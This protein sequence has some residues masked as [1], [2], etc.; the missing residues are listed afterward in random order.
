MFDLSH[1]CSQNLEG[2]IRGHEFSAVCPYCKRHGKFSVNI[3]KEVFNCFR[4]S[5]GAGG[6]IHKLIAFVEGIS[7]SEAFEKIGQQIQ[8]D[9]AAHEKVRAFKAPED[10]KIDLPEE[11]IP[12]YQE[13]RKPEWRIIKYLRDRIDPETLRRFGV[14]FCKSGKYYNRAVI[15]VKS[16][17]GYAFTARD[18]SDEWK[19]NPYR[20]KYRNPEGEWASALLFGWEQYAE[21]PGQD[22]VIVEGPFDVLKLSSH[23]IA[24][25]ALLG[26][27]LGSGQRALLY[28]LPRA[29]N[30]TLLIDPEEKRY[31]LRDI[32]LELILKFP[33]IYVGKLPEGVDPGDSTRD[34]AYRSIDT[35]RKWK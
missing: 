26:K 11:F 21:N 5:C 17:F 6:R 10:W 8:V 19:A 32:V 14:G 27:Q 12:C 28:K 34:Q 30:I 25:V 35:A 7:Y 29:T 24:A 20:P 3:E 15:P 13:G 9:K 33:N 22:L 16:P 2:S 18:A 1:W 31:T 4:A 23:G